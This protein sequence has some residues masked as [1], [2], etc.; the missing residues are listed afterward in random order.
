MY[1]L[2]KM[3]FK[4]VKERGG[5]KE[6]MINR[7]KVGGEIKGIYYIQVKNT[8]QGRS[9]KKQRKIQRST[10]NRNKDIFRKK[11]RK[12]EKDAEIERKRNTKNNKR[13]SEK[14]EKCRKRQ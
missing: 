5:I 11:Q 3:C 4:I 8:K 2:G 14:I 13:Y 12:I 9:T 6:L 10:E 7:R 1:V